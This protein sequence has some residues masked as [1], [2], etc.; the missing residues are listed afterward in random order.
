MRV[1][2]KD[3]NEDGNEDGGEDENDDQ[4]GEGDEGDDRVEVN[5]EQRFLQA[6]SD[7]KSGIPIPLLF[8]CILIWILSEYKSF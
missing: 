8:G 7:F 2:G 4:G 5:E 6:L 1:I 3:G